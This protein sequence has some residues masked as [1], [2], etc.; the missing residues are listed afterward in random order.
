MK[1]ILLILIGF[2]FVLQGYSQTTTDNN[3][4][5]IQTDVSIKSNITSE[6]TIHSEGV[7]ITRQRATETLKQLSEKEIYTLSFRSCNYK[8]FAEKIT[9][10]SFTVEINCATR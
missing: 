8:T 1:Q 3:A 10:T 2:L 4:L 9:F 7:E 6:T 5:P